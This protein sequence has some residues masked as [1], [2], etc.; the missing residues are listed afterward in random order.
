MNNIGFW[1]FV[2][3]VVCWLW[4]CLYLVPIYFDVSSAADAHLSA[5]KVFQT[6]VE[7]IKTLYWTCN[8]DYKYKLINP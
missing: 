4:I 8:R 1:N 7:E 3:L 2:G 6:K 5:E